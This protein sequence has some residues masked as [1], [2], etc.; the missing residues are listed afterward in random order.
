MKRLSLIA[1]LLCL[2]A[3]LVSP[4]RA[5]EYSF[6]APADPSYGKPTSVE[7]VLTA[8]RSE[9]PNTDRS[10]DAA[11]IPPSLNRPAA[12]PSSLGNTP[13]SGSFTGYTE[14][15]DGLRYPDGSLGTLTIPRLGVCVPI[16][17]GTDSATLKKGAGHFEGA[18]IWDGN[19][20]LAGHNRGV[21]AI[22]GQLHTLNVGDI[23]TLTTLLG[24]RTYA[25]TG[26]EKVAETDTSGLASTVG[27]QI[28]LYTCVRDQ[29]AYRWCVKGV[30]IG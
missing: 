26:V 17:E 14:V 24:T 7:P 11:L 21:N 1:A 29:P 20:C 27:N 19:C 30:E 25:V 16:F 10:K 12:C 28:T 6:T 23:I 9:L 4:A 3:F 18:S 8:D 5:L 15:T 13:T 22:F 2:A